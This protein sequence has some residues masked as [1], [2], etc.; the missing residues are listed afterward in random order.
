MPRKSR[1]KGSCQQASFEVLVLTD[2]SPR[3]TL[4]SMIY[5]FLD[6]NIYLSYLEKGAPNI[7]ELVRLAELIDHKKVSL[8]ITD[9]VIDEYS[10]N[11]EAVA[12][13]ALDQIRKLDYKPIF[14]PCFRELDSCAALRDALSNAREAQSSLAKEFMHKVTTS[15]LAIDEQFSVLRE[16][17]ISIDTSD[18]VYEVAKKRVALGKPPKKSKDTSIGDA[19]NWELLVEKCRPTLGSRKSIQIVA[20]DG[21]YYSKFDDS[22]ASKYLLDEWKSRVDTDISFFKD[23]KAFF[24]FNEIQVEATDDQKR[25]EL[26]QS[27]V[28]SGSFVNTNAFAEQLLKFDYFDEEDVR[29]ILKGLKENDQISRILGNEPIFKLYNLIFKSEHLDLDVAEKE[30]IKQMFRDSFKNGDVNDESEQLLFQ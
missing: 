21:D 26:I 10:R 16:K 12:K 14:P 25:K 18:S 24:K 2:S 29:L 4:F 1:L 28:N 9:Q 13:R 19:V 27:L 15:S 30:E 22:V 17:A 7:T 3:T 11:R 20:E 6:T 8:F 23:L 5:L